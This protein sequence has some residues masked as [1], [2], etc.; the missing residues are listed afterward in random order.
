MLRGL[1]T[2][3]KEK[4]L[5]SFNAIIHIIACWGK[6]QVLTWFC[7]DN[8]IVYYQI[9]GHVEVCNIITMY[10]Y[11]NTVFRLSFCLCAPQVQLY[12]NLQLKM[13]ADKGTILKEMSQW[14]TAIAQFWKTLWTSL[15]DRLT[16]C[17]SSSRVH[18]ITSSSS[19]RR[20]AR[21]EGEVS[22]EGFRWNA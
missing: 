16:E 20:A 14:T 13:T 10:D 5:D 21:E 15:P 6:N 12:T 3:L 22:E 4:S 9:C 1:V 2:P 11:Q 17:P 8:I 19:S 18:F 7:V